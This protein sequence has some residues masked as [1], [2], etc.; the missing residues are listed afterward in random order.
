MTLPGPGASFV[1]PIEL[2]IREDGTVLFNELEVG[3]PDDTGLSQL[4]TRLQRAVELFGKDQPVIIAPQAK[5]LHSRVVNVVDIC[6][7]SGCS[8]VSFAA[9]Q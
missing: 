7:T 3:T 4:Q 5:V 1:P 8:A 6:A 9:A 2:A